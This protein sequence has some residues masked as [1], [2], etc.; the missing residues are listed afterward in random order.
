MTETSGKQESLEVENSSAADTNDITDK[1]NGNTPTYFDPNDI[2]AEKITPDI[3]AKIDRYRELKESF[4][5]LSDKEMATIKRQIPEMFSDE[6]PNENGW[7]DSEHG[8]YA[9]SHAHLC[10]GKFKD[11]VVLIYDTGFTAEGQTFLGYGRYVDTND[12]CDLFILYYDGQRQVINS[13]DSTKA[14]L[15]LSESE[16]AECYNNYVNA[17]EYYGIRRELHSLA[18][19]AT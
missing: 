2:P 17:M 4:V 5:S 18:N 7:A 16:S 3:Q 11:K 1:N 13:G 15:F 19:S 9:G 8:F 10:I 6:H 14:E 12:L